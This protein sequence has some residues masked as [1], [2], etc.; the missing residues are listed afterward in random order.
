MAKVGQVDIANGLPP[1]EIKR[2][3]STLQDYE[4]NEDVFYWFEKLKARAKSWDTLRMNE[5][6][7][8]ANRKK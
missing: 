1:L 6:A 4:G 5:L 3:I 7:E 2:E 8:D